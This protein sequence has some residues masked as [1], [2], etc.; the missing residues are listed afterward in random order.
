MQIDKQQIIDFLQARGDKERVAQAEHEL[1][2]PV[3][4]EEH[5]EQI[6]LLGIDLEDLTGGLGGP[7]GIGERQTSNREEG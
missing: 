4:T 3:D 1:P 2:D 7:G 6:A 5:Q